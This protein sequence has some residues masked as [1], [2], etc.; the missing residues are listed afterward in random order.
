MALK[1]KKKKKKKKM[2]GHARGAG[3]NLKK[4]TIIFIYFLEPFS[5]FSRA[6]KIDFKKGLEVEVKQNGRR[7]TSNRLSRSSNFI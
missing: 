2:S 6:K 1:K 4:Y 5:F 7:G 3:R